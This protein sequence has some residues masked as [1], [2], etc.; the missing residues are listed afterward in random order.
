ML[1]VHVFGLIVV[2]LL[3][4][5]IILERSVYRTNYQAHW[6]YCVGK[7]CD[8]VVIRYQRFERLIMCLNF[9]LVE[10]STDHS[11]QTAT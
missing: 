7:S 1:T 11:E 2:P 8:L 10:E 9:C 4:L 3:Y 6:M 5:Q